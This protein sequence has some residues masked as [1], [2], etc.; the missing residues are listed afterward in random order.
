MGILGAILFSLAAAI[1]GWLAVNWLDPER[2][3]F[4][5]ERIALGAALGSV[6]WGFL[7]LI[8]ALAVGNLAAGIYLGFLLV[9]AAAFYFRREFHFGGVILSKLAGLKIR[10]WHAA[11]ISILFAVSLGTIFQVLFWDKFGFPRAVLVGWG[12]T[13]YHLDIVGRLA[14]AG[15]FWLEQPVAS[16]QP[17]TYPPLVDFLSAILVRLGAGMVL[18]WYFPM[19]V[20]GSAAFFLFYFFGRRLFDRTA[21]AIAL[22]FLVLFGA[23]LGFAW[24]FKD[25]SAAFRSGGSSAMVKIFWNPP[26][27]YTHL[28]SRTGGKP[29]EF[30]E[31]LNIVWMVPLVSFFAHQRTF[32]AGAVLV[33]IAL[34]GLVTEK[35]GKGGSSKR[36][37]VPLAFLPMT[38]PHSFLAAGLLFGSVFLVKWARGGLDR[39]ELNRWLLAGGL[40]ALIALPQV[41]Y[42]SSAGFIGASGGNFFRPWFGWMTCTHKAS[43]LRCAPGVSGTDGNAVWFWTKNFGVIFWGWLL[44]LA[45]F[46]L[47]PRAQSRWRWFIAPSVVLFLLPNLILFQPWEFDNNKILFWWWVTAI[48]L[49][50]GALE[51]ARPAFGRTSAALF[52]AG[53]VLAGGLAGSVDVFARLRRA[54]LPSAG[55]PATHFGFYGREEAEAANWIKNN[56]PAGEAFL[57][58]DA[59]DNFVPMLTGRPIYMGFPGWLWTQGRGNLVDHRRTV[60][61]RFFAS[62]D[63]S[64]LC[65][66]G[67]GWLVWEPS[68]FDTYPASRRLDLDKIGQVMFS[69][70]V[71]RGQRQIVKLK[72][73][74]AKSK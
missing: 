22:I 74:G 64:E 32:A 25:M 26:H 71:F 5:G 58:N 15:R 13:A 67:V 11:L 23:G 6:L 31:P 21:L 16:G 19:V 7:V 24:F 35:D 10:P 9:G 1:L 55:D 43:W 2:K 44:A 70:D 12:D 47:R 39:G 56:V 41:L 57:T 45:F 37:L 14:A 42:L 69:Q 29:A 72:C 3:F 62:A 61:E 63:P 59:A 36:W 48:I 28:D 60:V 30:D 4:A 50:I 17:L 68:L 46:A 66:Q 49:I 40:I 27:E 51:E 53:L 38:H 8:L 33:L 34:L 52:F 54:Y 73:Q 18:A 65:G 20:F